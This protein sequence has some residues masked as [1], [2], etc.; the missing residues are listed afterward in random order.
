[1][2][3]WVRFRYETPKYKVVND[4]TNIDVMKP[5]V[6]KSLCITSSLKTLK[7]INELHQ[8]HQSDRLVWRVQVLPAVE[9]TEKS[10]QF[11]ME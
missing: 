6:L 11:S 3:W 10:A 9:L 2:E 5:A 7:E 8:L 4:V 1:M